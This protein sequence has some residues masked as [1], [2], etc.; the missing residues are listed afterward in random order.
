MA[1]FYRDNVKFEA[2]FYRF[3]YNDTFYVLLDK[4]VAAKLL[5]F[6]EIFWE[7]WNSPDEYGHRPCLSM[8]AK[9]DKCLIGVYWDEGYDELRLWNSSPKGVKRVSYNTF[10]NTF[11]F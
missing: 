10:I 7:T 8:D 11:L 4:R 3:E 5:L 2:D 6:Y 9:V 1:T